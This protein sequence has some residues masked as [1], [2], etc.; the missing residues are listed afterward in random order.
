MLRKTTLNEHHNYHNN[1]QFWLYNRRSM[2]L[3]NDNDVIIKGCVSL[4]SKLQLVGLP[5]ITLGDK[6]VLIIY[7]H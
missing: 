3:R 5:R 6:R 2:G 4:F 7:Y 1:F